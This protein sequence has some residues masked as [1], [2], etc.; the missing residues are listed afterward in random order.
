MSDVAF[1][2]L[3][4]QR[5]EIVVE[6]D[7]PSSCRVAERAGFLLEGTLYRHLPAPDGT[8]KDVKVYS[9]L[10]TEPSGAN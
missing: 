7:N 1:E 8:L 4:A 2:H 5:V 10:G 6:V 9:R 3:Q